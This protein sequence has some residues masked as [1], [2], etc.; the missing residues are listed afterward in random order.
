M[1][2]KRAS[3]LLLAALLGACATTSRDYAP[4]YDPPGRSVE[5]SPVSLVVESAGGG[6]L[7]TYALGEALFVEGHSGEGYTLRLTNHTPDRFE[8]VIT[9]DGRDVVSGAPGRPAKQRGYILGP[10]ES[11]VIDGYRRSLDEVASFYFSSVYDSY[12][13]RR[14]TPDNA[15]VIGVALFEEKLA[16]SKPKPLTRRSAPPVPEPFP[17]AGATEK[18]A[19][20]GALATDDAMAPEAEEHLGTGYGAAAYSPVYETDFQR[21]RARRPDATMTL[22]Y[23]SFEGLQA[24]G[25]IPRRVD[26]YAEP[27]VEPYEAPRE[28][29]P[30]FAPPP[31]ARDR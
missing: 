30:G 8:A 9:V 6:A 12:S 19:A 31:W 3:L 21:R 18:S 15:G 1:A 26:P 27:Y 29:D 25:I 13:A 16:K 17:A 20:D 23:D 4:A 10:Y 22:Y 7:P 24:R 11:I 28:V 5:A 14:G 2:A